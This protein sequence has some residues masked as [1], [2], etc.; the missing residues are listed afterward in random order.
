MKEKVIITGI[1]GFIGSALAEWLDKDYTIIGID[2]V[3]WKNKGDRQFFNQDINDP[4]P[5]LE[6]I[7]AVIH[8]AA[9]PGVRD[10]HELFS[11]VC[12]DNILGTQ[13]I[14]DK[15]I[16]QWKPKKILIASSSSVYG[17]GGRDGHALEEID[18]RN[19]MSPY[20]MSKCA[21]E[22][23]V[24]T[25]KNAGFLKGIECA[26]LRFFTVYGP[27]Q[28]NELA[29]RAFIDWILKDEPIIVYGTGQQRRDFTYI[30]D[31]CRGI[32]SLLKKGIGVFENNI[33]NIGSGESVSL[34]D[35]I[36]NVCT[37]LRKEVRIN[38][39]PRNIWDSEVTLSDSSKLYRATGWLPEVKFKDGLIKQIE[40][41]RENLL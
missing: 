38:Y 36:Y 3:Q 15:C 16:T 8:L 34:Y 41:Q 27:N 14:L 31:I 20:A 40:W 18:K 29:I 4:L 32:E 13:R 17:D 1:S 28:R 30:D 24:T 23:L 35:I 22:D 7:F 5:D 33:Y 2:R 19:P 9:R 6:D 26:S 11:E 21:T 39:Q 12:K 37:Y 10:S 25:Y